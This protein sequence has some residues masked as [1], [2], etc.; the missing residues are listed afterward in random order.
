MS[1]RIS[2]DDYVVLVIAL[3]YGAAVLLDLVSYLSR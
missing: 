1:L 3:A 2:E